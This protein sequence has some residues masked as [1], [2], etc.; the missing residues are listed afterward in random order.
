MFEK[1]KRAPTSAKLHT[2]EGTV[3]LLRMNMGRQGRTRVCDCGVP[4]SPAAERC[5]TCANI[6]KE[7]ERRKLSVVDGREP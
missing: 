1:H 7:A 4:I 6:L 5:H 3:S 2:T